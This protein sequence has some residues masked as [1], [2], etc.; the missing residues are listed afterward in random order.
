M[1]K[2]HVIAVIKIRAL[3]L[4]GCTLFFI[5]SFEQV[6]GGDNETCSDSG[7]SAQKKE[8]RIP[9]AKRNA[10]AGAVS[11]NPSFLQEVSYK[12]LETENRIPDLINTFWQENDINL[13]NW[14]YNVHSNFWNEILVNDSEEYAI[15]E[16]MV[17]P[18]E[19]V[20]N[21]Q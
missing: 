15:E 11:L 6:A 9:A 17:N 21:T 10:E 2:K 12:E 20:K 16:W 8:V 1:C 5:Q 19:W 13:E 14:M 3:L 18:E 7:K 4:A